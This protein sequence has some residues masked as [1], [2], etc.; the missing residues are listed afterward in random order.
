M[1]LYSVPAVALYGGGLN[2]A[3]RLPISASSTLTRSILRVFASILITSPSRTCTGKHKG[4]LL[5]LGG[6]EV[7][8]GSGTLIALGFLGQMT[9]SKAVRGA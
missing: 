3:K 7:T 5:K 6:L 8:Q 2:S 4:Q 9:L 1:Y